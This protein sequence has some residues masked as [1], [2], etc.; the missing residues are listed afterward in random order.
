MARPPLKQAVCDPGFT[1]SVRDIGPLVDLLADDELAKHA[2]RAIARASVAALE[3]LRARFYPSSP[4]LRSR[5]LRAIARLA[6]HEPA[7]TVLMGALSD[8]DA[9]TRRNAAIALGHARGP[10]VEEALLRAWNDDPR[11]EMRRSIAASLGKTGTARSLALLQE[12]SRDDDAELSRIAK[13]AAIMIYRTESRPQRGRIDPQRIAEQPVDVEAFARHGIEGL[14]AEELA[15]AQG[16]DEVRIVAPGRVRARLTGPMSALF[17][18]RT[19]LFFRF[20]LA[21]E[22]LQEG[23]RVECAVARVVASSEAQR[24]LST[25]T[26]GAVRYRIAWVGGGHK[27][28]LS[29]DTA[30]AIARRLPALVNDPSASLW[31]LGVAATPRFVDVAIAPRE[32]D[33]PRFPWRRRDVP[34]ASHPTIAAALARVAGVQ[35]NDVVWDPF[36]GSA[37]ELIERSLAG[38]YSRLLGTDVD[39]RALAAARENLRAAGAA[40]T[41]EQIDALEHAPTGVTLVITNPPM[42]RRASRVP[43]LTDMLDR[44]IGHAA[45]V[46]VPGGRLV[47]MA[48]NPTRAR[49]AAARAGLTLAK[50][51]RV[52]MGGFDAELQRWDKNA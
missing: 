30:A 3:M 52:D 51:H 16:I 10:G 8:S 49:A 34:A 31:E 50:A 7:L 1:P 40:A 22:S 45:S 23:E 11:P 37:A 36:V 9:K 5:I 19:M 13:R 35:P 15:L 33:D 28:A 39:A 42:G 12:A 2:E 6:Q 18:A 24:I 47:W 29:W 48:P 41:L 20:P 27:R 25:W 32:V 4:P 43:Q 14:V 26:V 46:L 44:F 21:T 17:V 38:P